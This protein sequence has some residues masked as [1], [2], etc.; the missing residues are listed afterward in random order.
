[1]VWLSFGRRKSLEELA[2]SRGETCE[3]LLLVVALEAALAPPENTD[4]A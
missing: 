3:Q 4:I 1:V 2:A